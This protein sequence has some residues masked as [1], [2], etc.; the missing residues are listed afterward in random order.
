MKKILF[1][2]Y[3]LCLFSFSQVS[4]YTNVRTT[5]YENDFFQLTFVLSYQDDAVIQQ[6]FP[7]NFDDGETL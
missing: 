7:P 5:V 1:L 2:I 6:F 4:F 3:F